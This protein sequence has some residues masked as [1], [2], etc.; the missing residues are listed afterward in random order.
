MERSQWYLGTP[1]AVVLCI[2][3]VEERKI[4]GCFYHR[5]QEEATEFT[6]TEHLLFQLERFYDEI[7]FPYPSTSGRTFQRAGRETEIYQ[8][9]AEKMSE[10]ELLK[11]HGELGTF[12]V[13]V[14][15]RQNNSWQGRI[16]WMEENQT[17]C[18]RS[19]WEMLKLIASVVEMPEEGEK[20]EELSWFE[21]TKE[22][23]P[24]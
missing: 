18:F 7:R 3:R 17:L 15:H 11:K 4:S 12:I 16:T 21:A 22:A 13:L 2:H 1:N 20:L 5:Y 24:E 19:I 23:K 9:R 14:Q 10:Q 8:E 6:N